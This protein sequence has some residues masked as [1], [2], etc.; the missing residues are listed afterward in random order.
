M[1]DLRKRWRTSFIEAATYDWAVEREHVVGVLGRLIWGTGTSA[2]YRDIA[3]LSEVL[4]GTSVLD[5]PCGGGVAFRGLRPEHELDYGRGRPLARD[6]ATGPRR[7]RPPR[8]SWI[9][10]VEADV[11]ALPFEDCGFEVVVTYTG[12]HCFPDPSA[13]IAEIARVLRPRGELRGTSVIKRA[14]LR[15]DTFVR[16]MPA[17]WGRSAPG[18]P[19]PSSGPRLPTLGW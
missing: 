17:R 12:L 4:A 16:L 6:V 7:G 18:R 11:E 8:P 1:P 14:G 10:F 13:A 5:I 3:R 15:Q 2:F 9:E 19:S